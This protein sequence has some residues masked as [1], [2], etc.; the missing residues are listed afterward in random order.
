MPPADRLC[1]S[2]FMLGDLRQLWAS[3]PCKAAFAVVAFAW[4]CL[5]HFLGNSVLGYVD[6]PSI[7][8]WLD[9]LHTSA[10]RTDSDDAFGRFVPWL[11]LVLALVRRQELTEAT[12]RPWP[13]GLALLAF[14][15]LLHG[16]GFLIQQT[17]VSIVAFLLGLY[18]IMGIAWGAGWLK[19]VFF[20]YFLLGFAIPISVYLD[21]LTFRLRLLSTMVSTAICKG[22][23]S[24]PLNRVGTS[25]EFAAVPPRP[26]AM[27]GRAGFLFDVAPACS[28]IRSLTIVTLLTIAFAWLNLRTPARRL[29]LVLCSAPLALLGNI[30]RLTLT[31]AVADIWGQDAASKVETKAGFITFT[32]ALAGVFAIGRI[33]REPEQGH[34]A[35]PAAATGTTEAPRT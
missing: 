33:L 9:A 5:F 23:L 21:G 30:V 12:K 20:P 6:T 34:G 17:R 1:G 18:A 7:F 22:I 10:E 13:A 2:L 27:E 35:P 26:G 19:A 24:I 3:L 28:G 11:V 4:V 8:V 31:F 16:A 25:V 29:L 14:A 15:I 32:V